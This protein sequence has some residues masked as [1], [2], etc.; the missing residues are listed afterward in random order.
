M[1]V[2]EAIR[3]AEQRAMALTISPDQMEAAFEHLRADAAR[4][5]GRVPEPPVYRRPNDPV[6]KQ[7]ETLIPE[8]QEILARAMA[9]QRTG[10]VDHVAAPLSLAARWYLECVVH[11]AAG[12]IAAA[13]DAW[14]TAGQVERQALSA[15][16]LFSRSDETRPQVFDRETGMSRFDPRSDASVQVKLACPNASCHHIDDFAFSPRH[17]THQFVCPRC[18]QPFIAYFGEVR[19][20][21]ME[22][23][24]G[25]SARHYRL[26]LEEPG[27]GLSRIEFEDGSGADL[28]ISRQDFLAFLYGP[29]RELQGVLNLSSSRLLWIQRGGP[30]FLATVAYGEHAPQLRAFRSFRD[31][32]LRPTALGAW[33]VRRY[34]RHG[35]WLA[36]WVQRVPGARGACRRVLDRI[37][38]AI[39]VKAWR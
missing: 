33:A 29:D 32:V 3:V 16:R 38:R 21:E 31:E 24:E 26:K 22:Q 17:A 36:R 2:D 10:K 9:F 20:V 12:R 6:R 1:Q 15:R 30:C 35:P 14:A 11:T 39:E 4:F 5:F 27:G 25:S 23:P 8:G 37:H 34:Y 7:A 13:E 28:S 19:S 18:Q